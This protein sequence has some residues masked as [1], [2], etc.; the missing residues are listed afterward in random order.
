[1]NRRRRSFID[2][3]KSEKSGKITKVFFMPRAEYLKHFA[4]DYE[5]KYIGTE[6]QKAWTIEELEERYGKYK[7]DLTKKRGQRG[8]TMTIGL[9]A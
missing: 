5:G 6:P 4:K 9:N 7:K 1:V 3:F 2:K 8:Q